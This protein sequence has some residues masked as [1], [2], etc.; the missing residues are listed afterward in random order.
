M[1]R[2]RL[3]AGVTRDQT[4]LQTDVRRAW[5]QRAR[6]Q[7]RA[8]CEEAGFEFAAIS[9]HF[10]PWLEEQN[11]APL[12]WPVLGAIAHATKRIGLMTAVTCPL[13]RYHPAIVAQGAS[14][15]G[16]L[17]ES[18]F[19]VGLGSGERLS[20]HVIGA[21]WPGRAERQERFGEA[22]DIIQGLLGGGLTNY[23]GQY[24]QLDHARLFDLPKSKVP[25]AVAAGGVHAAR[26]AGSKGDALID[27]E[28]RADLVQAYEASGG[29]G[30]RYAEVQCAMAAMSTTLKKLLT[31]S[32]AGPFPGGR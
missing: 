21:G 1:V 15:L 14:T 5:P 13:L 27:T 30:P 25:V 4:W 29:T 28:P 17:T 26:L 7:R 16:L 6:P 31:A 22:I 23:R 19:T 20:E 12:A 3:A 18:R 2:K 32:F 8:G 24:Y 10:S 11:H 9:D